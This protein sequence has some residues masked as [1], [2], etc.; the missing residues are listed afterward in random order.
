MMAVRVSGDGAAFQSSAPQILFDATAPQLRTP[1]WEYDVSP[2]GQ[3]FLMI[4]PLVDPEH[5]PLTI[6]GNW[7]YR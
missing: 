5:Q 4:E 1:N 7:R 6:V 3:R 2:D